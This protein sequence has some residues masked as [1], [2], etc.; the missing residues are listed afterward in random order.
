LGVLVCVCV[1]TAIVQPRRS[2]CGSPPAPWCGVGRDNGPGSAGLGQPFP[3]PFGPMPPFLQSPIPASG[4]CLC[5]RQ[6]VIHSSVGQPA[7]PPSSHQVLFAPLLAGASSHEVT[8]PAPTRCLH[9]PLFSSPALAPVPT[10]SISAPPSPTPT[11][12]PHVYCPHLPPSLFSPLVSRPPPPFIPPS[13]PSERMGT[14]ATLLLPIDRR[15]TS[16]VYVFFL[17]PPVPNSKLRF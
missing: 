13:T 7:I 15:L 14:G 5:R 3:E 6:W 1:L 12:A 4:V 2:V 11:R 16:L 10:H 8:L 17:L 9:R